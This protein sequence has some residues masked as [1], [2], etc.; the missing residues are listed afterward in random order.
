MCSPF[1]PHKFGLAIRKLVDYDFGNGDLDMSLIQKK[2]S[3]TSFA[4]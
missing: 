1:C 4:H 3:K 2:L